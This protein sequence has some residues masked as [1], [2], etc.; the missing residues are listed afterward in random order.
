[1]I[2]ENEQES[3]N[4]TKDEYL[5]NLIKEKPYEACYEILLGINKKEFFETVTKTSEDELGNI[6]ETLNEMQKKYDDE[7]KKKYDDVLFALET[8]HT[9]KNWP[10]EDVQETLGAFKKNL[11]DENSLVGHCQKSFLEIKSELEKAF[12]VES[13]RNVSEQNNDA[14]VKQIM[15]EASLASNNKQNALNALIELSE[16]APER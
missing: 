4:M 13:N 10:I 7:K 14:N 12:D 11:E 15:E 1:M 2:L 9:L 6:I 3:K 5:N 16:N 8:I